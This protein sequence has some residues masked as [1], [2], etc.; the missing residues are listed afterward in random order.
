[1]DRDGEVRG[2]LTFDESDAMDPVAVEVNLEDIEEI[3]VLDILDERDEIEEVEN[4]DDFLVMG[5]GG[6]EVCAGIDVGVGEGDSRLGVLAGDSTMVE[7]I[8]AVGEASSESGE[9]MSSG[10]SARDPE[11]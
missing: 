10:D 11:A 6:D 5:G 3:E 9:A 1:M 2:D 8:S 4:M 7:E